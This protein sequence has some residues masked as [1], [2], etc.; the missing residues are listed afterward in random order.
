MSTLLS[1]PPNPY[2]EPSPLE[3][4]EAQERQAWLW[5]KYLEAACREANEAWSQACTEL[6]EYKE[7]L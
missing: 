3:E 5:V 1:H 2:D 4:L 6:R 7:S